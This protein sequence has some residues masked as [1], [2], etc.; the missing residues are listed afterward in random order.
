MI[1]AIVAFIFFFNQKAEA[2]VVPGNKE[3]EVAALPIQEG[4]PGKVE[5]KRQAIYRAALSRDYEKLAQEASPNLNYSFGGDEE[6]GVAG[7]MKLSE[8]T[9]GKSAFDIIP[10]LLKLPYAVK[11]NLYSWPS[12]FTI[13]PSKWTPEDVAMMKTFLT[14]KQ[15]E[16]FRQFGGYIYYRLGITSAGEWTFY[17]AGD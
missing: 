2:P 4:L 12:V 11:N 6:G 14:E 17:L 7:Y 8:E 5:A 10:I 15:I 16:D 13:E 1:L 9:E 3:P